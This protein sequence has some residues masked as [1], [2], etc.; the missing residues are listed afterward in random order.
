[1]PKDKRAKFNYE[2]GRY[3][4]ADGSPR[5]PKKTREP[6]EQQILKKYLELAEARKAGKVRYQLDI[7]KTYDCISPERLKSALKLISAALAEQGKELPP[8][9][10]APKKAELDLKALGVLAKLLKPK[11]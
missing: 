5:E 2:T 9:A 10:F 1:M 7:L 6:T 3:E 4:Y 11:S 8:L